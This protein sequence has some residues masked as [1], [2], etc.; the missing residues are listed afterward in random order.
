MQGYRCRCKSRE[1]LLYEGSFASLY[2][3]LLDGFRFVAT[4]LRYPSIRFRPATSYMQAWGFAIWIWGNSTRE[5]KQKA[6][7]LIGK[8]KR[9]RLALAV[10]LNLYGTTPHTALRPTTKTCLTSIAGQ[11]GGIDAV[12]LTSEKFVVKH[13]NWPLPRLNISN[14]PFSQ[15]AST[16]FRFV[17]VVFDLSNDGFQ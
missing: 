4:P 2:S 6:E 3:H 5:G 12:M 1:G 7:A 9:V 10:T 14:N 11:E 13:K 17:S 8:L 15:E 16:Q